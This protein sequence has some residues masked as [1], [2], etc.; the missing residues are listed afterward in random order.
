MS[1][2]DLTALLERAGARPARVGKRWDCPTCG[3]PGRVSV[4]VGKGVFHC[5]HAGCGFRGN[6]V[7]LAKSLGVAEKLAPEESRALQ[8]RFAWTRR[9]RERTE[10]VVKPR[11]LELYDEHQALLELYDRADNEARDRMREDILWG[12]LAFVDRRLDQVKAELL[13]LESAPRAD[14]ARYLHLPE[15]EKAEVIKRVIEHGGLFDGERRFVELDYPTLMPRTE[16]DRNTCEIPWERS[17]EWQ[18]ETVSVP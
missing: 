9:V 3:K 5:F 11:R 4:D 18:G 10:R 1:S 15:P 8:E 14:R 13:I 17:P 2:F 7:T 16:Q 12:A 6:T